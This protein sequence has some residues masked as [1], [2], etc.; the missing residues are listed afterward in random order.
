MRHF[1]QFFNYRGRESLYCMHLPKA[2]FL[3]L[4]LFMKA[5]KAIFLRLLIG[6]NGSAK[7]KV[8]KGLVTG[9]DAFDSNMNR[10]NKC[11]E[12]LLKK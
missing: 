7:K 11:M 12:I 2:A 10:A 4:E 6:L 5:M 8:I 1:A 3:I 9:L